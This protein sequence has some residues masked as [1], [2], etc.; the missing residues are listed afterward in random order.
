MFSTCS[1]LAI[2][3]SNLLSYCGLVDAR[4][5]A[6]EKDLPVSTHIKFDSRVFCEILLGVKIGLHDIKSIYSE[7]A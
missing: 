2:F 5:S 3:T 6:S 7:S 1:E 4:I